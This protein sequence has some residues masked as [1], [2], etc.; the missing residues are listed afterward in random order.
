MTLSVLSALV[1]ALFESQLA[2]AVDLDVNNPNSI[3]AAART[4]AFGLQSYYHNNE[5]GVAP[6]LVGTFPLQSWYW[7]E[8]G[9]VWG[10]MVDYWAYTGDPSYNEVTS[11]SLLAQVGPD[12]NYMPPAYQSSLGNDDQAFWALAVLSALEYDY[13]VP[14]GQKS[15]VWLDLATAVFNSQTPR[16]D[17]S[18]C[19]G[20]LRWQIFESNK[21]YNYKNSISNGALFQIAARLARY[22]GNETYVDWAVKSWDWMQAIGLIG[23]EYQVY[24]GSDDTINC[25]QINHLQWSYNPAMLLY[26]TA[27]LSNYTNQQ[28]WKDRTN[29]L[30]TSIENTFFSPYKNASSVM[31]E[32]AC[33]PYNSC[34]TDQYSFKAYLARWMAKSAMVFPS[35]TD[36]VRKYLQ[37]SAEAAAQSCTGGDSACGQKWYV[38]G[39]DGSTGIGQ[40]LSALET[41][42]SLL[43]LDGSAPHRIPEH[44]AN[45]KI[46]IVPVTS[47]F[48]L[49]P[50]STPNPE[51][52]PDSSP[53]PHPH[54]S[55][56]STNR[57]DRSTLEAWSSWSTLA[58]AVVVVQGVW[59]FGW[60]SRSTTAQ[61]RQQHGG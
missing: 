61:D 57:V 35:I 13:P 28:V 60:S 20:G 53:H 59:T 46:P 27:A 5:T 49:M 38:G 19:G 22:T 17:T 8:A 33:E 10:G 37:A 44:E 15:T 58:I 30:L 11:Q 41:V 45:V 14:Q 47:E 25:T 34:D 9:A 18:S 4:I 48:P 26:G 54:K 39:Y 52:E 6:T 56:G 40:E 16:W 21:G 36:S 51:A 24:D 1:V 32:S 12:F 3:R 55:S 2:S 29:G 42:Q 50:S 23:P 31:Y 7:W 43:L